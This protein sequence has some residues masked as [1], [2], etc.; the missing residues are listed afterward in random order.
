MKEGLAKSV[1]TY[2]GAGAF[3][4]FVALLLFLP[5]ITITRFYH[6][7]ILWSLLLIVV[8]EFLAS[9]FTIISTIAWIFGLVCAI[10]M[11]QDWRAILYYVAFVINFY[12]LTLPLMTTILCVLLAPFGALFA[13]FAK[14]F[15]KKIQNENQ[16]E[17]KEA[18]NL[19]NAKNT[20]THVSS[21]VNSD[22]VKM[23]HYLSK[24]LKNSI[25]PEVFGHSEGVHFDIND[26]WAELTVWLAN[27][28]ENELKS[29]ES[30]C[31]ELRFLKIP[32][33]IWLAF[34]F[35]KLNLRIEA[36]Y[37]PHLS[38]RLNDFTHHNL[39]RLLRNQG[40]LVV[41]FDTLTGRVCYVDTLK[42]TAY[43]STSLIDMIDKIKSEEVFD[44]TKYFE[45]VRRIQSEIQPWKLAVPPRN[46][47]TIR[48]GIILMT[49]EQSVEEYKH[50]QRRL[51]AYEKRML[52][53]ARNNVE[54]GVWSMP[55]AELEA[56]LKKSHPELYDLKLQLKKIIDKHND[57]EANPFVDW[58]WM[59]V[60]SL[61][62]IGLLIWLD[63]L[64]TK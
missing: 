32:M 30:K 21:C 2:S 31:V 19:C 13:L 35:G 49:P 38:I 64:F 18:E 52:K 7:G 56:A 44:K 16:K 41:V 26:S 15:G 37:S 62:V 55:D 53:C 54:S 60:I 20:D 4:L 17:Q 3:G 10:R 33:G 42:L 28:T 40:I 23:F 58:F 50:R 43:F 14:L 25:Y 8:F 22:G 48:N 36:S 47:M 46:R 24:P 63:E 39:Q 6:V 27:P 57:K 5:I 29:F 34:K 9:C 12:K 59:Y 11:E 1:L 61:I 51:T 45:T